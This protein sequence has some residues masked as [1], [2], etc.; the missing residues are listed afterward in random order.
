[1]SE[2][3]KI[4]SE[5]E[6]VRAHMPVRIMDFEI[7]PQLVHDALP[8]LFPVYGISMTLPYLEPYLIRTCVR[9]SSIAPTLLSPRR[10]DSLSGRRRSTIAS[11]QYSMT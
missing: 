5:L 11:M 6:A 3:A 9:R 4:E 10:S 7:D 2:Q 8:E 1:M